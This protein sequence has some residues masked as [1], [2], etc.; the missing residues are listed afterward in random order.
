MYDGFSEISIKNGMKEWIE[1]RRERCYESELYDEL[2]EEIRAALDEW[3]RVNIRSDEHCR[4]PRSSYGLKTDF[5]RDTG[6]YV[7]SGIMDG[8]LAKAG[9]KPVNTEDNHRF[10]SVKCGCCRR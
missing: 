8:A 1:A 10:Y 9:Y 2:P 3:I 4:F 5:R 6:I 7:Y